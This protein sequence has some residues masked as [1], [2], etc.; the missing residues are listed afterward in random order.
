MR[1]F[2]I[3][4][5]SVLVCAAIMIST[6]IWGLSQNHA[7]FTHAFTSTP[8]PYIAIWV[9]NS[10]QAQHA[11][12][13]IENSILTVPVRVSKDYKLY[14]MA[15]KDDRSF[16]ANKEEQQKLTPNIQV[17]KG[18]RLSDYTLAEIESFFGVQPKV[19]NLLAEFPKQRF[20]L[21]I[22]DN[23]EG[24]HVVLRDALRPLMVNDRILINSDTDV[25]LT[26]TKEQV[27]E[28]LYGSG[29]SDLM[30]MLSFDSIGLISASP[31]K[32]DLVVT[33]LTVLNRPIIN[34]NVIAEVRRRNK[35]VILGP[36]KNID[37]FNKAKSFNPD[38]YI[39]SD[40]DLALSLIKEL[41]E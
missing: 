8:T 3:S 10:E 27:P 16:L 28:W 9:V 5:I 36:L 12:K 7:P 31:F 20:V 41:K 21:Q 6:R 18:R 29:N 19:E 24:I 26:A 33:P 40:A 2:L 30:R 14:V 38:G 22:I 39:F 4:L 15:P 35:K 34:S 11:V 32:T 25:I 13:S 1:L 23:A 17:L 37:D